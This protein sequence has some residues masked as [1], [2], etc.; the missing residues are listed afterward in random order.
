[1][2]TNKVYL[3]NIDL[4]PFEMKK[5]IFMKKMMIL[6]FVLQSISIPFLYKG[7]EPVTSDIYNSEE[8]IKN[9]ENSTMTL[10]NQQIKQQQIM[11]LIK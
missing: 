1:M 2:I 3:K 4:Y 8:I 5:Y 7:T 10:E 9:M 6:S 11:I